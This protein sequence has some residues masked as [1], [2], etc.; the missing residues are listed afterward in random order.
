MIQKLWMNVISFCF[1][2]DIIFPGVPE[3]LSHGNLKVNTL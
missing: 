1:Y 3:I 2:A